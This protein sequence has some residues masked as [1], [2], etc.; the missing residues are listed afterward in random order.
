MLD[1]IFLVPP[2]GTKLIVN[3]YS[4]TGSTMLWCDCVVDKFNVSHI[5]HSDLQVSGMVRYLLCAERRRTPVRRKGTHLL[6]IVP[7]LTVIINCSHA[8]RYN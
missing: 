5:L 8:H 6:E 4:P 7:T 3:F 1:H 2:E